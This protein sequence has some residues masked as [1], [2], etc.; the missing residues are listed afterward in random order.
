[1]CKVIGGILVLTVLC[2]PAQSQVL[3]GTYGPFT[4]TSATR[5]GQIEVS[6]RVISGNPQLPGLYVWEYVVHNTSFDPGGVGI[7]G[8]SVE[9]A[10]D[11]PEKTN[12]VSPSNS[13]KTDNFQW[14]SPAHRVTWIKDPVGVGVLPGETAT[15]SFT[16]L[17]RKP[18]ILPGLPNPVPPGIGN[19]GFS[20]DPTSRVVCCRIAG[21]LVVPSDFDF[22]FNINFTT[23]IPGNNMDSQSSHC[24]TKT[25][26][27]RFQA[28]Y[29]RLDDR[30]FAPHAATYRS[31]QLVTVIP[32]ESVDVDGLKEGSK[33]NLVN[34][35]KVYAA[36]ALP[37]IDDNDDDDTLDD[38]H[39]L[40][41]IKEPIPNP[42]DMHIDV[43]RTGPRTVRVHLFG[44]AGTGFPNRIIRPC[45]ISWDFSLDVDVSG[46]RP[47]VA[48]SGAHDGF[49]AYE[50]YVDD[51]RVYDYSILPP[52][53][54][55]HLAPLCGPLDIPVEDVIELH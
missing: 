3:V 43:K 38:C 16:T 27:P 32:D 36:D 19:H 29:I 40:V 37:I 9:P 46:Q 17:P 1:M 18:Q 28:L 41:D 51:F 42:P 33:R 4:W 26:P 24:L 31:R 53:S 6:L 48:I 35:T 8:F 2:L 23:F 44:N 54:V 7:N 12:F 52:T 15:F 47:T 49:P 20:V 13:W 25:F 21:D 50:I 5:P 34:P 14:N 55:A 45:P 11:V 22:E 30:G 39:L 10:V